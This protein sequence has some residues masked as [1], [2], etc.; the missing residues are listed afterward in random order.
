MKLI[1]V[2]G[3]ANSGKSETSRIIKEYLD[4]SKPFAKNYC[5][6]HTKVIPL[7]EP[8]KLIAQ[9]LFNWNGEKDKTGRDL[10]INIG[11]YIG[12]NQGYKLGDYFFGKD[13]VEITD[14]YNLFCKYY[15]PDVNI[16][17]SILKDK[18]VYLSNNL[19]HIIVDDNRFKSEIFYL[20]NIFKDD[21]ITI[22]VKNNHRT[23]YI[24]DISETDLDNFM[25]DYYIEN[26]EDDND[27][28]IIEQIKAIEF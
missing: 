17:S 10:L 18:A 7:A 20:R 8:V 14:M 19:T 11:T 26:N 22:R 24:D 27:N 21:L 12:R 25:F 23:H 2:S 4:N 1:L 28:Y 5:K 3:K 13:G 9:T 15:T 16:W 6:N